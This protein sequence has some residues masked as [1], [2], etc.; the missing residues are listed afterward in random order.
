[1]ATKANAKQSSGQSSINRSGNDSYYIPPPP[2]PR[3]ATNEDSQVG[4]LIAFLS[5]VIVF[6]L[7]LPILGF[8]YLDILEA[9]KETKRQQE[10]VQR[11][12]NKA[13]KN[14]E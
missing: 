8:M 1:M 7:L 9:K 3:P 13:E 14:N 2:V 12:I 5:M 11:L 4:F 10:Q 6:A